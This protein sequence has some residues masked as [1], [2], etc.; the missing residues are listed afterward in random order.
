MRSFVVGVGLLS[1]TL[2]VGC[3]ERAPDSD[4][5]TLNAAIVGG[6]VDNDSEAHENVI[7]LTSGIGACSGTLVA[8]N[9][10]LT[11][12]HC[13]AP[14][15]GDGRIG[16][17]PNGVSTNGDHVGDDFT[18]SNLRVRVGVNPGGSAAV[19]RG[20][21][22][23]HE[24]GKQLCNKDLAF[25]VL[26]TDVTGITPAKIRTNY[27]AIPGET[28]TVV[29]YGITSNNGVDSGI[30]RRRDNV[31]ILTAGKDYNAYQ[32][33]SEFELGPS[34]CSG[35]SGGPALDSV[36]G[37]VIGVSSRVGNC[38]VG[39]LVDTSLFGHESL[40]QRAF[41]AAGKTALLEGN[42]TPPP[43]K[44]KADGQGCSSGW[45]CLGDICR[46]ENGQGECTKFCST[47]SA[48]SCPDGM[49]CMP[50]S[51]DVQGQ[52]FDTELCVSIPDDGSC[53]SCR[54][55]SCRLRTID[56]V[57]NPDCMTIADCVDGC[58]DEACITACID[59]SPSG[60]NDYNSLKSCTCVTECKDVCNG[61]PA[62]SGGSGAGGA[63]AGGSGGESSGGT[64]GGA[65]GIAGASGSS[66]NSSA[67]TGGS[68][69]G[70]TGGDTGSTSGCSL[71]AGDSA[72]AGHWFVG[73]GLG[74]LALL[75]RRRG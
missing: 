41:A 9:L 36:T 12:W 44:S 1:L 39:P 7:Y 42:P 60:A 57:R 6:V 15:A 10:V 19:A 13:V 8:S 14:G 22:I 48:A 63:S 74:A 65:G 61:C 54:A 31:P 38:N 71:S 49:L 46:E 4:T 17:D 66:G 68:A 72:P 55:S 26:D 45:E 56:C 30:R 70:S 2:A 25:V 59:A 73:L 52:S 3:S 40:V 58:S 23:L 28:V 24:D 21:E 37:A 69:A 33:S 47:T 29:G 62:G 20:K 43:I 75:R 64:G 16:C 11:A 35:D 18:A 5:E 27:V 53:F 50:S 51:F 67:G 34:G 32:A